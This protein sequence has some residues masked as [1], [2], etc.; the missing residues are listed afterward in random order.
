VVCGV[1]C[2]VG[3]N[4]SWGKDLPVADCLSAMSESVYLPFLIELSAQEELR[5]PYFCSKAAEAWGNEDVY[6]GSN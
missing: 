4:G 5:I 3:L 6:Q 2:I 1:S